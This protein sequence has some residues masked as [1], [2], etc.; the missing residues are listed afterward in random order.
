MTTYSGVKI[1]TAEAAARRRTCGGL[2]GLEL[3]GSEV[4]AR[5]LRVVR[6]AA[7][8]VSIKNFAA[9]SCQVPG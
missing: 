2:G 8:V 6:A 4:V 9:H 7:E 3:P 1:A 5:R